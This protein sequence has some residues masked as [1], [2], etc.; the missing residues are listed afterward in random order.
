MLV[1][2]LFSLKIST[3]FAANAM[4]HVTGVLETAL[5]VEDLPRSMQFYQNLFHFEI[6]FVD[7]RACGMNVAGKQVLLLFKKG[8][9]LKPIQTAGGAIPPHDGKGQLHMAF[10]IDA[11]EFDDWEQ[12]LKQNGVVIES[13]INW[14]EGGQS[15]YFRDPDQHVIELATPGTWK[16]Y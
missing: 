5:Y 9:S 8:A 3:K 2:K 7:D 14:Q 1:L 16:I 10:S 6:L 13:K 15:L 12:Q 4:P 11:A